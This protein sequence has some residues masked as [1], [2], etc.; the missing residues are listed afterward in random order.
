MRVS[1]WFITGWGAV[2]A[3]WDD[4]LARLDVFQEVRVINWYDCLDEPAGLPRGAFEKDQAVL[5]VGWS[6]GALIALEAAAANAPRVAGL[7][8]LSSTARLTADEGYAG[9][10]RD[11]LISMKMRLVSNRTW[12]M[13]DF[14]SEAL[15]PRRDERLVA[16]LCEEC[17]SIET[18]TLVDGLS[19]LQE[20]DLRTLAASVDAKTLLIHGDADRIVPPEHGVWLAENLPRARMVSLEGVGHAPPLVDADRVARLIAEFAVGLC[21]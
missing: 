15:R 7:V 8:L 13:H 14:L 3:A 6:L 21:D 16:A 11:V 17:G 9:V 1:A 2:A 12:L 18:D 20:K 5:L 10:Q 19:F 4:V